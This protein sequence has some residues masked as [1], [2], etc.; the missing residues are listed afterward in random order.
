VARRA[1]PG[2]WE[3]SSRPL[4]RLADANQ[5]GVQVD[6]PHLESPDLPGPEA[7]Q[8][9]EGEGEPQPPLRLLEGGLDEAER[10]RCRKFLAS[11]RQ[12]RNSGHG[13]QDFELGAAREHRSEAGEG[14]PG[15]RLTPNGV[16]FHGT[17]IASRSVRNR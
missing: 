2:P 11:G 4:K 5:P 13:P 7:S 8:R 15:T 1:G 3:S 16:R 17:R 9:G 10:R 6:V 12:F 14:I